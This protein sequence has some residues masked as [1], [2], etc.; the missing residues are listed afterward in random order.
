MTEP[1]AI[2]GLDE[3]QALVDQS[4]AIVFFGGAGVSTESGVPDFRSQDGLYHQTWRWPPETI[5]SHTFFVHHT[6]DFYEFYREKLLAPNRGPNPAHRAL[7]R[8]EEMGK[9]TAV[10]TQHGQTVRR[11]DLP[12]P[13]KELTVPLDDGTYHLTVR[14]CGGSVSVSESDCPGQDCVRTGSISRA[15]QSIVCLPA[16]VVISLESAASEVDVVLG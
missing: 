14:I 4:R 1:T 16:Q 2:P 15:G 5:L 8:L 12:V 6:A 7:A 10:I 13:D 3:L 11:I 9:L